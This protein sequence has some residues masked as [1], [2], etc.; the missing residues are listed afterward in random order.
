MGFR[1]RGFF[2]CTFR[3]NADGSR[4]PYGLFVPRG[5][6][7]RKAAPLIVA[8]HGMN[9]DIYSFIYSNLLDH[10]EK[11]GYVVIFPYARGNSLYIR[12]A[13][14][15][16][17][18]AVDAVSGLLKIDDRRVSILGF[19]MGGT[20]ALTTAYHQ[21]HR[22]SAV[23]SIMGDS[24]YSARLGRLYRYYY[25]RFFRSRAEEK[26]YS[27]LYFAAN[28]L[29][30]PVFM[31]QGKADRVSPAAQI[32]L[33]QKKEKRLSRR[34]GIHFN[35]RFEL[36]PGYDHEEELMHVK[37]GEIFDFLRDKRRPLSPDRVIFT[38]N[39]NGF[40]RD[41]RGRLRK[42]RLNRAYWLRFR[43][44]RVG[45]FGTVEVVKSRCGNKIEVRRLRN[46][47]ALFLD[48]PSMGLDLEQPIIL[49][50]LHRRRARIHL[51]LKP[52][53]NPA[54]TRWWGPKTK[55]GRKDNRL[56]LNLPAR[57]AVRLKVGL[58]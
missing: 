19:S 54:L 42:R 4:Q 31:F 5:Y 35:S 48:L 17:I 7:G 29:N 12:K 24:L 1:K 30:L 26:R 16:V 20:G 53:W 44:R 47:S 28:A 9:G 27:I 57:S 52:G 39:S 13:E 23:V 2:K 14:N 37:M 32:R 38:S 56:I 46:V 6:D 49:A 10:A 41:S 51:R 18:D 8:L 50:N 21:P 3:S 25:R 55:S 58:R 34:Y 22:F 33:L 43:L 45:R 36:V 15:D 11:E 40:K